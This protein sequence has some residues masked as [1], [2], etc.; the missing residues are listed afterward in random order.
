MTSI[1]DA[2]DRALKEDTLIDAL[3]SILG[4]ECAR[5]HSCDANYIS[6][7]KFLVNEVATNYTATLSN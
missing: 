7:A 1:Q 5:R 3:D 6:M 2:I 4:W